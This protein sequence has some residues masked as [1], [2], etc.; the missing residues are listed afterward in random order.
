MTS[1]RNSATDPVN[2]GIDVGLRRLAVAS[3]DLGFAGHMELKAPTPAK[4]ANR[5]NELNQ[6]GRWLWDVLMDH[7]VQPQHVIAWV[8]R[9]YVGNS[10]RNPNTALGL[11]ETVGMVL[12][13]V[14]WGRA[15]R[16]DAS[17]WKMNLLG[18]GQGHATKSQVDLWLASEWPQL[19]RRCETEDERD[20]MCISLYGQMRHDGTVGPPTKAKRKRTS[21]AG[22]TAADA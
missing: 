16:V 6:L 11:A 19:Y 12:S 17:T 3:W 15:E 7:Q 18:V 9:S 22:R 8:E 21:V 2:I 10:V 20:A 1:M 14:L 5:A 4:P 13:T